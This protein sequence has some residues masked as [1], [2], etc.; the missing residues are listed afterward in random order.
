[1]QNKMRSRHS[2]GNHPSLKGSFV[3]EMQK[4]VS[5]FIVTLDAREQ[6]E[7]LQQLE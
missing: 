7:D 3:K 1:M 5:P 2:T 6:I 4:G